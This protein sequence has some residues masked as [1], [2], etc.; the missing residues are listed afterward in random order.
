MKKILN[1]LIVI[2]SILI[3]LVGLDI[4][5][6]YNFNK[7]IF[8]LKEENNGLNKIYRGI[9]YDAYNCAEYS[10]IQIKLKGNKW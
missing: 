8:I 10:M 6:I 3:I 7:P 9:F 5:S 1:S 2:I 4:Y